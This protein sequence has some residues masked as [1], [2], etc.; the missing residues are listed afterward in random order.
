MSSPVVFARREGPIGEIVLNR[1]EKLN[2]MSLTWV[3]DLEAAAGELSRDPAVRVVVVR[4]AGRAFCAGLDLDMMGE[5][6]MPPEF[7]PVQER[8]FTVLER[9]RPIV[10]AQIHG[11]CLGGGLQLAL[12]CDIRV[13]RA[14][15]TLGLPATLEGL[16]PG[17]AGW[18]LPRF[19]GMGRAMR[20]A[21]LG[22]PIGATEA[23]DIGLVD[24]LLP[25]RRFERRAREIALRYAEIPRLAAAGIKEQ[26]R[27]AFEMTFEQ[28]YGRAREIVADCLSSPDVDLAKQAWA[29]RSA[30]G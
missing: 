19:V 5:S 13:A 25:N 28:S 30:G 8:A 4:G 27:S 1:P 18:R 14:D 6:G 11:Y 12:A 7:F 2:A 29:E 20:L 26:I 3:R 9:M 23:L 17:M 21:V 15:A 10:V 24:H 22:K 16:I